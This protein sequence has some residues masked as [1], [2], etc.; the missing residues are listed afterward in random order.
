MFLTLGDDTMLSAGL[1]ESIY[2][3]INVSICVSRGDLDPNTGFS[4]RNNWVGESDH[5]HTYKH[6]HNILADMIVAY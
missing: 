1:Y 3:M 6:T 2:S 5:I 4:F